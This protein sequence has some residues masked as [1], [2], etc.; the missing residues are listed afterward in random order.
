MRKSPFY[1]SHI[2]SRHLQKCHCVNAFLQRVVG[3][4]EKE[5][6]FTIPE[7]KLHKFQQDNDPKDTSNLV[8]EW[9]KQA[10]I[11]PRN[12]LSKIL[13]SII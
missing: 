11:K 13:I 8:V 12:V 3:I 5:D 9:R 7:H 2:K 6:C 10:N 1:F 4:M